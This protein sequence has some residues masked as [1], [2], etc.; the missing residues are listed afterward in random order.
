MKNRLVI[1]APFS[2][3]MVLSLCSTVFAEEVNV[4]AYGRASTTP[5]RVRAEV[6]ADI[7]VRQASTTE[8]R[9]RRHEEVKTN[10]AERKASSTE[11]RV[12]MQRGLAKRKAKHVAKVILATI[13]RLEKII[14][15]IES[16]ID[17]VQAQGGSTAE[18]GGF[19][20][21]ARMNLSDARLEVEAFVNIDLSSDV[22]SE[23][24]E[25]VRAAAA[26]A[27]EHIRAAHRNLMMAV[28]SLGSVRVN[29]EAS[30]SVE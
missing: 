6:K 1:A 2:V 7:E 26:R 27:R 17:K 22:A 4:N 9:E 11:R 8:R 16:R 20:A 21:L 28:R 5:V 29:V 23:N 15:R 24:F 30:S 19:I 3:F 25:R 18:A 12:E 13:E 10:I 14:V